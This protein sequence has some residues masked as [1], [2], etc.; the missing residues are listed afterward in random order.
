MSFVAC[1]LPSWHGSLCIIIEYRSIILPCVYVNILK[2]VYQ[3]QFSSITLI[4]LE[5]IIFEVS[6]ASQEAIKL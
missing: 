6:T 4:S 2:F 5:N 3:P 1:S